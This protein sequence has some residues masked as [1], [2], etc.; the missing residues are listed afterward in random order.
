MKKFNIHSLTF[1]LCIAIIAFAIIPTSIM[2]YFLFTQSKDNLLEE[3]KKSINSQLSL[4]SNN[5]DSI[6]DNMMDNASYFANN[7]SLKKADNSITSYLDNTSDIVMTPQSNGKVESDIFNIFD[8]FGTSHPLYQYMFMGT[9]SGGFVLYPD[10]NLKGKFDPRERPWY[11]N[12]KKAD[13]KA[14]IGSPYYYE[15]DDI[16]IVGISQAVK[17]DAGDIVGVIGIDT[18]LK[19][20]TEMF[21]NVSKSSNGYY[22]LV[23]KDG[24][25]IADPSN[26]DNNFKK[27]SKVYNENFVSSVNQNT[28]FKK[29]D[30]NGDSSYVTSIAS[31]KTNWNYVA[32]IS[33]SKLLSSLNEMTRISLLALVVILIISVIIA[34]IIA[35]NIARPLKKLT[36]ITNNLAK[37]N[38]DAEI[39]IKSNDE[40]G[41]LAVSMQSLVSRLK[42]YIEYIDEISYLLS[43]LG[44]GN[45]ELTFNQNY[46]GEFE[47]IKNSLV[48]TSNMLNSTLS[49][50]NVSAEQ[51]AIG[52]NQVSYGAQQLSQ[53][54]T[55]Q[56]SSI[57]ELSATINE[58]ST[59]IKE[60]DHSATKA[61][62]ISSDSNKVI[63]QGQKQMQEMIAAMDEISNTSNEIRK[64]I[65]NIDDVAFQTNI[66][67]LNAAVEAA[68]AGEAGKGF[69]VVADEVRNLAAKS[70]ESAKNTAILIENSIIAVEKG[71]KTVAETA[72]SLEKVVIG[73]RKSVEVI[74][75][76]ADMSNEQSQSI[77]QIN[78]GV[79]Q[80]SVVIQTNSATAEESAAASEELSAQAVMLTDLLGNFKLKDK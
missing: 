79:E 74:Q 4:V 8:E 48:N 69:A 46:D 54:A 5:I 23:D 26:P 44:K 12:A 36:N 71:T 64:I 58:I 73:S 78:I 19:K 11:P 16:S 62:E 49:Q 56:A 3:Q 67:A 32:V 50:I 57:E 52:S 68:R 40:I 20:V 43:E 39:S 38:L 18:S 65:K 59:K 2:S 28:S 1:K 72:T 33:E 75:Y 34:L 21:E 7:S 24:T 77:D 60:T 29:V 41:Q 76:I 30:V 13:G 47:L 53:G 61:K 55:E 31:E 63:A 42:S 10:G 45:L 80:I 14:V 37:G 9:E 70:A 51:V 35:F 6:F 15:S 22:M 17:N 66:L 25:I 27:L